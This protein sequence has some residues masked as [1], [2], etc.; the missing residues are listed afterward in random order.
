VRKKT[1]DGTAGVSAL[2]QRGGR[3]TIAATV[4]IGLRKWLHQRLQ[5]KLSEH[6]CQ[7]GIIRWQ[8][9]KNLCRRKCRRRC[10]C[11][12]AC[13]AC[14]RAGPKA[15][16]RAARCAGA[17]RHV[18]S[19]NA[20]CDPALRTRAPGHFHRAAHRGARRGGVPRA[21]RSGPAVSGHRAGQQ[22]APVQ[23]HTQGDAVG[24]EWRPSSSA[25]GAAGSAC[26]RSVL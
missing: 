15:G 21:G 2:P 4:V 13:L 16:A 26:A 10:V 25:F 18:D 6:P 7:K 12:P 3:S 8:A 23:A 22:V 5:Q 24:A 9:S 11:H 19:G 17:G 20:R 14:G 1:P